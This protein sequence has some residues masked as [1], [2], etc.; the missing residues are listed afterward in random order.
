[1]YVQFKHKQ[2]IIVNNRSDLYKK[3]SIYGKFLAG[4]S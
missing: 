2:E 4:D 3:K 1:M